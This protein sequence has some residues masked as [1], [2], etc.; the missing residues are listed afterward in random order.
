MD[1]ILIDDLRVLT[2][3]GALPHEREIAQP[4]RIDL[5]LGVDLH[6]AGRSDEL[7]DTVH[8][9][10]VCERVAELC[11]ESKDI[12]LERLAA[13]VAD[14]VLEFDLVEE[15]DVTLTK[16]RPPIPEEVQST[17]VHL[18]RTRKE[19]AAPPLVAHRAVV[20]LGS[21]LGDRE[22]YLRFAVRELGNVTAMSQIFETEP[23]GG[24]GGQGAFLNMVVEVETALDPFAFLRRCQRIEA[25]ALRQRLV[26][27][28]PRT[29]DVD[30]LFY[31]DM[32]IES[33][34]LMLPHPRIFER[35]FVL[36]PLA[37]VAPEFC[38]AD[39]DDTLPPAAVLP[40][41]PLSLDADLV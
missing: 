23:I 22:G 15:V 40:R 16:L 35:R 19:A 1:R 18:V 34:A 26:R 37:E 5:A 41:G 4:I 14:T 38:P 21:N 25:N 17:A 7:A 13:K 30:L 33:E 11:R 12:L 28:G 8:Y 27:W 39:W 10:L 32:R 2:V 9:G 3:I 20:A 6:E 24:P 29:L 31:D 36:A